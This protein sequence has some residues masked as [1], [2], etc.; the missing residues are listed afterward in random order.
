MVMFL[1]KKNKSKGYFIL[2]IISSF[3]NFSIKE[4]EM[5]LLSFN[6][7]NNNGKQRRLKISAQAVITLEVSSELKQK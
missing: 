5:F 2:R 4:K 3:D 7:K 1:L 6:R